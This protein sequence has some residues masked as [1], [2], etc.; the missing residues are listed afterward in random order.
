MKSIGAN[1]PIHIGE[2]GWATVCNSFYGANGS[3]ATD[4]YKEAK[5]YELSRKWTNENNMACHAS[6]LK[7]LMSHGKAEITRKIQKNISGYL[8]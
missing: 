6:I 3:K 4:E 5:F 7:V 8:R 2:I 1:K